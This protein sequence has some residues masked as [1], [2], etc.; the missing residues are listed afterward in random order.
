MRKILIIAACMALTACGTPRPYDGA[1]RGQYDRNTKPTV[2][3][4]KPHG[5]PHPDKGWDLSR[6][7]IPAD[8]GILDDL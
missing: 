7:R 4:D 2:K 8:R 6:D 1:T 3:A 5:Y